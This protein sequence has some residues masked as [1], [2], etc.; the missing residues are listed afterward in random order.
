MAP[1]EALAAIGHNNPPADVTLKEHL[2]QTYALEIAKVG[3]IADLAN[4]LPK[5]I[6]TDDHLTQTGDVVIAA[7]DLWKRLDGLRDIEKRPYLNACNTI[8]AHFGDHLVRLKKIKDGLTLRASEYNRKKADAE[9]KAREEAERKAREDAEAAR[10]AAEQAVAAGRV[11]DAIAD[12]EDAAAA[13]LR[14]DQAAAA[15]KPSAAD[16][17]RVRSD[18]G[19]LATSKTEWTFEITD[20]SALDLNALRDFIDP[21]AIDKALRAY[22]KIK[23]GTA[24]LAGVRFFEQ[25]TAQFRRR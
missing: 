9:R 5:E 6:S 2:E 12:M 3:P 19:A 22:T 25:E 23:K 21:D 20:R 24:A 13:R 1:S 15:P 11:E 18:S 7:R 8:Q 4:R 16:L 14:A 10:K 17:T